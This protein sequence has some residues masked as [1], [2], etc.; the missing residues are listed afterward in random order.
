MSL[1]PNPLS[2]GDK[3]EH[4]LRPSERGFQAKGAGGMFTHVQPWWCITSRTTMPMPAMK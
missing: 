3:K 1:P 4:P 2:V